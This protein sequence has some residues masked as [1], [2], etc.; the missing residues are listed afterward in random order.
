MQYIPIVVLA[1]MIASIIFALWRW[2]K[3]PP[4]SDTPIVRTSCRNRPDPAEDVLDD[5][6]PNP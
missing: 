5:E 6:D 2:V 1:T 3:D 4:G